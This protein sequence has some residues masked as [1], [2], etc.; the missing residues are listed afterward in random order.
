MSFNWSSVQGTVNV[1]LQ[2]LP[3][4]RSPFTLAV[5]VASGTTVTDPYK[6]Y[7]SVDDI[8]ADSELTTASKAALT[9]MIA[10]ASQYKPA[11]VAVIPIT[12]TNSTAALALQAAIDAGLD[13]GYVT[14]DTRTPAAQV[15]ISNW[16]EARQYIYLAQS[17]DASWLNSG[18]PT[19]YSTIVDNKQTGMIYH[20]TDSQWADAEWAGFVSAKDPDVARTNFRGPIGN[21]TTYTLTSAQAAFAIANKINII[22]PDVRGDATHYI[23]NDA[24]A[25]CS[26]EGEL[27]YGAL[28][29]LWTTIKIEDSNATILQQYDDLSEG[30][31]FNDAGAQ[32]FLAPLTALG[33]LG[34]RAGHYTKSAALPKG[35]AFT[36]TLDATRTVNITAR[37]GF[38]DTIAVVNV[39]AYLSR[40]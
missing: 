24:G 28:T 13:F 10:P 22:G 30:V 19:D 39:T 17:S 12:V 21:A 34:L 29:K 31:P 11:S 15:A 40:S 26:L 8:G 6:L 38:L 33:E 37:Y 36:Y 14:C 3:V 32:V 27:L 5:H 4:R 2:S 9:A 35:Y 25:A 23:G 18:V 7:T 16:C 20:P 1:V